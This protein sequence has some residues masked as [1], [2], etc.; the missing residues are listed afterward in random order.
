[1]A[2]NSFRITKQSSGSRTVTS[3]TAMNDDEM[4][5]ELARMLGGED[6]TDAVR[7]N[8]KELI[9]TARRKKAENI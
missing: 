8:A 4:V 6:I 3:I 9:D 5:E 7:G 2:D 1:M